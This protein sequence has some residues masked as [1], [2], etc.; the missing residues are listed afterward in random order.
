MDFDRYLGDDKLDDLVKLS[1]KLRLAD[2]DRR[3]SLLE[4]IPPGITSIL[5]EK[6]RPNEQ[7][8]SDLF[9]L[10]EIF[11][12]ANG[13]IPLE[14][15][16]HNAIFIISDDRVE[17]KLF[18]ALKES[19]R[20]RYNK[21]SNSYWL[22]LHESNAKILRE[23]LRHIYLPF[24]ANIRETSDLELSKLV[25]K[26]ERAV[27][28]RYTYNKSE[29]IRNVDRRVTVEWRDR[30][31]E[32]I[33]LTEELRFEFVLFDQ[34]DL[35]WHREQ[36]ADGAMTLNDYA[37]ED[38]TLFEGEE[39][40]PDRIIVSPDKQRST[41]IYIRRDCIPG[42]GYKVFRRRSMAWK[43]DDDPTFQQTSP[44][45][46]ENVTLSIKN[47][48]EG[49]SV[50]YNDIGG[51]PIFRPVSGFERKGASW[52]VVRFGESIELTGE[53]VL[54]PDQGYLLVLARTLTS[55]AS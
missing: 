7:L 8:R 20:S 28:K 54:L 35:E 12:A 53:P 40:Q 5:A 51:M 34:G 45:V 32:V 21:F 49:L 50:M 23:A 47:N 29:Y 44:Y 33:A 22:H 42:K 36:S 26:L 48:A 19:V 16:L 30:K 41:L 38:L 25:E 6:K 17:V 43:I 31:R 3:D 15:W 2:P 4:R 13:V 46:A 24:S 18:K 14:K 37:V 9:Q 52:D 39:I 1:I 55:S 11:V 10:N 27:D